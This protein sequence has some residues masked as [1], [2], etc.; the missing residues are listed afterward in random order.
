LVTK[1]KVACTVDRF[2]TRVRPNE[3]TTQ[4]VDYL[5]SSCD[6]IR[7]VALLCHGSAAVPF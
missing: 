5:A 1:T 7:H 4:R 6:E 3:L 2:S